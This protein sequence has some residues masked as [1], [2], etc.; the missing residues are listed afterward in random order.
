MLKLVLGEILSQSQNAF[1]KGKHILDSILIANECVYNRLKF[2][3]LG[4][5]CKL[6]LEKVY[7]AINC[8]LDLLLDL[9]GYSVR[10]S[11]L[12]NSSPSGFFDG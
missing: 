1:I 3:I 10:L 6:D 4:I 9:Y 2:S 11:I 8:K 12:V 5:L 7:D